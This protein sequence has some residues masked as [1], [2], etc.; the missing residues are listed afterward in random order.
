VNDA[1]YQR[2]RESVRALALQVATLAD[3]VAEFAAFARDVIPEANST[4]KLDLLK[5]RIDRISSDSRRLA[6]TL[7]GDEPTVGGEGNGHGH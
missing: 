7:V 6:G 1:D 4:L 2:L 3:D 5:E